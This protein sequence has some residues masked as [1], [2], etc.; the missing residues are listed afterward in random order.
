MLF[1]DLAR[2]MASAVV[3]FFAI[4][5]LLIV[6]VSLLETTTIFTS[7][8]CIYCN[9]QI[10]FITTFIATFI[11]TSRCFDIKNI[12]CKIIQSVLI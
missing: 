12:H 10:D 4:T 7:C 11:T 1:D 5:S 8:F 2:Q 9:R 3:A 6:V